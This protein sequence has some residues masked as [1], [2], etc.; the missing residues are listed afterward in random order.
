MD[1]GEKKLGPLNIVLKLEILVFLRIQHYGGGQPFY[2]S[3]GPYCRCNVEKMMIFQ[4][5]L[6][7]VAPA[8]DTFE[9]MG[10]KKQPFLRVSDKSLRKRPQPGRKSK[11]A[12]E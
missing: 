5:H 4:K 10:K 9:R 11:K 2:I 7:A 12:G 1:L 3:I 6:E 8:N